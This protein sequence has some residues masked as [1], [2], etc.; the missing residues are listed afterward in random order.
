MFVRETF[1]ASERHCA[2]QLWNGLNLKV[3]TQKFYGWISEIE[4]NL[5]TK[6]ESKHFLVL[7]SFEVDLEHKQCLLHL[8][9][10][11]QHRHSYNV[12]RDVIIFRRINIWYF[13]AV[14]DCFF[15]IFVL[16][17]IIQFFRRW[18]SNIWNSLRQCFVLPYIF[19][20]TELNVTKST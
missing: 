14:C 20:Y 18:F 11:E 16:K 4:I 6:E 1:L 13:T 9:T 10:L 15:V 2:K 8:F 19:T 7:E 12:L 5:K 3:I 17:I